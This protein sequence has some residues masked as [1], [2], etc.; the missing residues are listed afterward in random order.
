MMCRCRCGT[1]TSI[2]SQMM[3]L[4]EWSCG[5][6][7]GELVEVVEVLLASIASRAVEIEHVGRPVHRHEY[8]VA[9][10]D[11]HAS[12]RVARV[13]RVF[14]RDLADELHELGAVDPHPVAVDVA[15]RR[16]PHGGRF[17]VAK[18]DADL[19]EDLARLVVNELDR[20][21]R[22]DVVDGDLA[23]QGGERHRRRRAQLP[24][25][26]AAACPPRASRCDG[27]SLDQFLDARHVRRAFSHRPASHWRD[28]SGLRAHDRSRNRRCA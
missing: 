6:E 2:G 22:H 7:I 27:S 25:A 21:I 26:F 23:H 14:G 10:P 5:S 4:V 19:L 28:H 24:A 15:A 18:L 11:R 3:E 1:A 20:F 9:A 12:R 8:R 13:H 17:V 16:L